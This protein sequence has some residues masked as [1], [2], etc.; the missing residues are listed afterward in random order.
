LA[1]F[2]QEGYLEKHINRMRNYYR[3]QRNSL[4][5]CIKKSPLSEI[6]TITEEDSG[7]HFLMHIKTRISE[8]DFMQRAKNNGI[9]ISCLTQYYNNNR[10]VQ[11]H[12]YIINYS[13]IE[14]EHIEDAICKL[15]E[16]AKEY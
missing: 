13:Y 12:I 5:A 6:I 15:Y 3:V 11:S 2:I 14:T 1:R 16:C 10:P 7:L 4:L 9:N 8:E